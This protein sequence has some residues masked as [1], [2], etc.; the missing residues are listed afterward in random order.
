MALSLD[1]T[2]EDGTT[3]RF[4]V[5]DKQFIWLWQ[6]RKDPKKPRVPNPEVIAV[7]VGDDIHKQLLLA[8]DPD[9]FFTEPHYD[10]YPAV[11]VRLPRIDRKRLRE[12]VTE[13]WELRRS[14]SQAP[15]R[16]PPRAGRRGR[17]PPSRRA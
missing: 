17:P 2:S 3:F 10:G 4:F 1:D 5:D 14:S 13:A 12:L 6:E 9:V 15:R 11:L 16:R 8:E 7:R